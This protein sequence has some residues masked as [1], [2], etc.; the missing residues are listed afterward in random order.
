[1][2]S[3]RGWSTFPDRTHPS[4]SPSKQSTP[5]VLEPEILPVESTGVD[6]APVRAGLLTPEGL[7]ARFKQTLDW[8]QE[9]PEARIKALGGDPRV[10]AVLVPLVVRDGG[11]TVLLTQR[12]DHLSTH[13][14][15]ISFPGGGREPQD[16]D[17]VATALR[18][19]QEE[20]S[21]PPERAEVIGELPD[22]LTATGF[23]V[24]PVIA[25]IH[26]PFELHADTLEVADIFEVPF[27]FL[28]NPANHQTRIFRW[29]EGEF[30]GERRFFAMPYSPSENAAPYFI[31]GATAGM[32]RNFYRFL[33]A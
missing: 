26:P 27:A 12:A 18:E 20:V 17:A 2:C 13:A 24:T 10:A 16:A 19:A 21:L 29:N 31:W 30:R 28:M 33:A 8:T 25:L 32:L 1:M 5:R 6:Q 11:L 9:P 14:G 7:R 3:N 23:R 15:Q 22:Y 4:V